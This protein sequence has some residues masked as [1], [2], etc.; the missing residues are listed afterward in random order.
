MGYKSCWL[1]TDKGKIGTENQ[2]VGL[3]EALGLDYRIKRVSAQFP[4]NML[5]PRLWV[6]PLACLNEE[7]APPWPSVI[8][9]GG[10]MSSAPVA[11]IRKASQGRTKAIQI[12]N[13]YLPLQKYDL[14]IAPEH[15]GLQGDNVLQTVGALNKLTPELLEHGARQFASLV[16]DLLRPL[17]AVLIGGSNKTYK[18]DSQDL[19]ALLSHL[20]TL[21]KTQGVGLAITV[22]RR[23]GQE[24]TE[25][26]QQ[27]FK[28]DSA[29]IWHGTGPNPYNG[30]LAHAD[31]ILVTQ[32][33]ISMTCEACFTGKP[34]YTIPLKG[35]SAKFQAFH[36]SL[37]N[38][39]HTRIFEGHLDS[40][41]TSP[42]RET[43]RVAKEIE[44]LS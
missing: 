3:A 21:S 23:T 44:H 31:F 10:R 41:T 8:I 6:N 5:P 29:V 38:K 4:W 7:I 9:G 36:E 25:K 28:D 43:Q 1:L 15:D 35:H 42:L 2:C 30:F 18:M 20:K 37:Q 27:A 13:P 12:L 22:S 17:V 39:G 32:D 34:V 16:K 33:S 40:W 11:Y 19:E 14:V 26:I 24:N